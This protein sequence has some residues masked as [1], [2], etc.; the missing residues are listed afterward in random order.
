MRGQQRRE[1]TR[2]QPA[3]IAK[4]VLSGV[5]SDDPEMDRHVSQREAEVDQQGFP[6]R[7]LGQR[8]REIGGDGGDSAAAFGAEKDEYLGGCPLGGGSLRP[9]DGDASQSIG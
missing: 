7:L 1:K 3:G 6:A 8:Y 4:G 5:I 9:A 2:I